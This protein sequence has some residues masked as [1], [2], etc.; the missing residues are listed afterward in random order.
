M[1]KMPKT[2]FPFVIS[3]FILYSCDPTHSLVVSNNSNDTQKVKVIYTDT[4]YKRYALRDSISISSNTKM[5]TGEKN[6]FREKVIVD[7]L[8]MGF[9]FYLIPGYTALLEFGFGSHAILDQKIIINDID[10]IQVKKRTN[11]ITIPN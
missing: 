7:T 10:T 8:S 9:S 2:I 1:D 6:F 4:V 5:P 3:A 11:K